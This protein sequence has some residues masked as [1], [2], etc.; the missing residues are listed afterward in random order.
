MKPLS[1][2]YSAE[3]NTWMRNN[4]NSCISLK[5]IYSIF[6]KAF[7]KGCTMETAVNGFAKTGIYPLNKDIFK[8]EDFVTL[9]GSLVAETSHAQGI[10]IFKKNRR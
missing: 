6:G 8:E 7:I 5:D 3:I 1:N 2:Y 10:Y 9:R 4:E